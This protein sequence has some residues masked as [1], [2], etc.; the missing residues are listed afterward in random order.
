MTV[1]HSAP[2][3]SPL[4]TYLDTKNMAGRGEEA[5]QAV[6]EKYLANGFTAATQHAEELRNGV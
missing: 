2:A 6:F 4:Q 3:T 5:A 1:P